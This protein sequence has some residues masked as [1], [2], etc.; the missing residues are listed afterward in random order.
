MAS[1]ARTLPIP[2]GRIL[3]TPS[4][5]LKIASGLGFGDTYTVVLYC[6]PVER[7]RR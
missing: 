2:G 1:D 5:G 7:V 3:A 4:S 6:K